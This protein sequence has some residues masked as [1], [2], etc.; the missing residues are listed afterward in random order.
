MASPNLNFSYSPHEVRRLKKI[1]FSVWSPEE[2]ERGSVTVK[3][4]LDNVGSVEDGIYKVN[5]MIGGTGDYGSLSD[6]RMGNLNMRDHCKTCN[7]TY[8]E[9]QSMD[10]CP[11]HFGHMRLK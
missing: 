6:K 8:E 7:C 11:G 10:N 2:I 3:A 4:H 9:G 5:R 1:Q